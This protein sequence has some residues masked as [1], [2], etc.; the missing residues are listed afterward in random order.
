VGSLAGDDTALL[1]MRSTEAAETLCQ[2]IQRM[3][4][5]G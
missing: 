3:L 1:I 4:E 5:K 2:E